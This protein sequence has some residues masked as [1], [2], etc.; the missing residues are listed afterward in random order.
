M[1]YTVP[2]MK[3]IPQTMVMSCWYASAQML[4]QWRRNRQQASDRNVKDPS[5]DFFSEMQKKADLGV[6]DGQ[7]ISLAQQLGLKVIPPMSPTN[8]ATGRV[9]TALWPFVDK[10]YETYHCHCRYFWRQSAGL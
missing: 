4:V 1:A 3:V 2:G 10:R 8:R 7:I 5:E 6:T 9:A